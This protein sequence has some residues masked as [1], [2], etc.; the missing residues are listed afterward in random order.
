MSELKATIPIAL[1][2]T[3]QCMVTPK[4]FVDKSEYSPL[5]GTFEL[6]VNGE[7]A[8]GAVHRAIA[9]ARKSVCI[10]CWG[11]QPSMYFMRGGNTLTI[12]Q[13]LEN[14]AKSKGVK[15]KI[16]SYVIDP[17]WLGVGV[18]GA[19]GEAN[20]PGRRWAG[21]KDRPPTSTD[22]QYRYDTEWYLRYDQDQ[23]IADQLGK[24]LLEDLDGKPRT[25]NIR[26][27]GRGFSAFDRAKLAIRRKIDQGRVSLVNGVLAAAP[28]HH[29][30][31]V[32]V[33][34]E[35][36]E[37]CVGFVMGH[38]MFDE[39]WDTCDHGYRRY[40]PNRGR[41]GAR[42]RED[43]SSQ[44]TGPIVGDVFLNF[45]QAW[46]KE[47]GETLPPMDFRNY[48]REKSGSFIMAQI[49]RTQSQHG[50]EDIKKC[51]LQ[52]VNNASQYIYIENQYFR[53]PPLAEKI[54]AC[55]AG[56]NEWGRKPETHGPLYLFVI[57]NADSEGM[58]AGVVKTQ[59]TLES[60]GRGDVLPEPTRQ[61]RAEDAKAQLGQTRTEMAILR[62]RQNNLSFAAKRNPDSPLAKQYAD[63]QERLK[64]LE[65][66]EKA[67]AEALK[68]AEDKSNTIVPEERPGLKAH[69]CTLVAPDTPGASGQTSVAEQGRAL[70][71]AERIE[72]AEA[73][74]K[75]ADAKLEP[76]LKRR[77]ALD[78][79]AG[80]LQWLP[81]TGESLTRRYEALN[82]ELQPAQARR[83]ALQKELDALKDGSNPTDWVDVYIH[84]KLML[85]DDAFMTL[86]S[87][88]I[89]TRS[90]EVDSELNI[91][92]HRPEITEPVRKRLWG[93]HT[94]GKSGEE[95]LGKRGMKIA[96]QNWSDIIRKNKDQR[97]GK[98]SPIASLI[99]FY[100]GTKSRSNLD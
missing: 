58:G 64:T 98:R 8:F 40:P 18:T 42:P 69:I 62:Q 20:T 67:Q 23:V 38:N 100:S 80:Q 17:L 41:N 45:A 34:Y 54:K 77:Q 71:R 4:W 19:A 94:N 83:D 1:S 84:A 92:H 95:S 46:K 13:L 57:T 48:A 91:A 56:Q 26:F 28:T 37:N 43:F 79:E 49:L 78:A 44:I 63:G 29:Q 39:Y 33:D 10:I 76:L 27:V 30:K 65:A 60:L 32:L 2:E 96:Y 47:T 25:A 59:Q 36:S 90:M 88:N 6:L 35:D 55:A 75:Q 5:A 72:R 7:A 86:G 12:G 31:T 66:Q 14:V 15:V 50:R 68:K 70:T 53:W 93:M 82:Q 51:Y 9:A 11:F 87:A 97:F 74:L 52:A 81:N 85:V 73:Q 24:S 3:K 61:Q 99:E 21:L 22:E 89:N 16:L